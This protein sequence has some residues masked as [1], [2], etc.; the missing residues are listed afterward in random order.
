M[1]DADYV[2]NLAVGILDSHID[3]TAAIMLAVESGFHLQAP[4]PVHFTDV[5]WHH[6]VGG[7]NTAAAFNCGYETMF[8]I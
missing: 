8:H 1:G 5:Y 7:V 6:Y 4:L 3:H 2:A